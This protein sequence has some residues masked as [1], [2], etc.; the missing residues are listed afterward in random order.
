[1][2]SAEYPILVKEKS[3]A[4]WLE[5][6]DQLENQSRKNQNTLGKQGEQSRSTFFANLLKSYY[7]LEGIEIP[8]RA[9]DLGKKQLPKFPSPEVITPTV[10]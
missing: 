1:M 9:A 8:Q 2:S 7:A 10:F 5:Q 4:L 6:L 3:D